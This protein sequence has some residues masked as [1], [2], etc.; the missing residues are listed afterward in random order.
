MQLLNFGR[1][2]HAAA[3]AVHANVF[4]AALAQQVDHVLEELDVPAL[5]RADRDALHV[6]LQSCGDD[7]LDRAVVAQVN[8]LGAHALQN[9]PH[10]VDRR[11]VPVEQRR[12][13]DEAHLVRGSVVGELLDLRQVGHVFAQ[14][15]L[16]ENHRLT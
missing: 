14:G 11:I 4:A 7:L 8:Y 1:D 6:F 3:A 15:S 5:I 12:R 16:G 13:S 2:D 9:A 10:D